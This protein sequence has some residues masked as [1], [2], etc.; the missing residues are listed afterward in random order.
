MTCAHVIEE[1]TG[2]RVFEAEADGRQ[3]TLRATA[4]E[5]FKSDE[6]LDVALLRLAEESGPEHSYVVV[7]NALVT[8]DRL[9]AFG[10]PEGRYHGGKPANFVCEGFSKL[11]QGT[12][13]QLARVR[14][15]PVGPG[16]SGSPVLNRRTGAVC[17]MLCT[18]NLKGSA[19]LL[20]V[21]DILARSEELQV[22][23]AETESRQRHWLDRLDDAQVHAGDWRYPGP[24]IRDYLTLA[25]Q[26]A[27]RHPYPGVVPGIAPPALSEV[28]VH[29]EARPDSGSDD[30]SPEG[31][32][33]PA[34]T[35][36]EQPGSILLI[37]GAGAGQVQP[38]PDRSRH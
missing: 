16:Y 14:G 33:L 26:A 9:W 8:G 12:E 4:D 31:R 2:D 7:S 29:P 38:A 30:P 1:D 21:A 20:R 5:C 35:V 34:R 28:Y 27:E 10:F 17:G 22:T 13:L 19:H 11:R 24:A 32:R 36:F 6:G 25:L 23:H 15:I 3:F 37:G 18:S